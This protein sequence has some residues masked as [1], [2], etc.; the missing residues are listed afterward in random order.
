M[1]VNFLA[2]A[3]AALSTLVVGF[4]WYNPKVFGN[5]WM[6]EVGMTEADAKGANMAKIFGLAIVYAFLIAFILQFLV[7]H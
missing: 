1:N 3:L 7:I 2:L 4:I 5:A 6:K